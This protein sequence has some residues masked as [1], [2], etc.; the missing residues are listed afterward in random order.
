MHLCQA[1]S[2]KKNNLSYQR[3]IVTTS[4]LSTSIKILRNVHLSCFII[5]KRGFRR[6]YSR[7]Y[8]GFA[9]LFRLKNTFQNQNHDQNQ[10]KEK[11]SRWIWNRIL[12]YSVNTKDNL[13]F[14]HGSHWSLRSLAACNISD[15][16]R[17]LN[18]RSCFHYVH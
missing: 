3:H 4:T 13:K 18:S 9:R 11:F 17:W 2:S 10:Y 12:Y 15:T 16:W 6:L 5:C 1:N 8:Y 14:I 7:F